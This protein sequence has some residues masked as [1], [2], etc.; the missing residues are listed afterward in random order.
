M[1]AQKHILV[2]EPRLEGHHLSWL[3]FVVEDFLS[4][5]HRL[6]LAID[7]RAH[8]MVLYREYLADLLNEVDVIS[9][10]GDDNHFKGR[11]KLAALHN[12]FRESRADHAF[13]NNLDD[14]ASRMLRR[15]AFGKF[16]PIALKGRIS[17]V[18]FRPRFLGPSSWSIN[19]MLKG[20]G[21]RRLI[22]QGWFHCICLLDEYIYR[23]NRATMPK[24]GL[25]F[26][27]DTW[28]G[29]FGMSQKMAREKL[30]I[31]Q[32]KFVFLNYGTGTR[33]KGLHLIVQALQSDDAPDHWHLLAAGQLG[34]EKKLKREVDF[35]ADQG[36]VTV[37]DRY[38]SKKEE[39]LCF[40]AVDVV[41]LPYV[42]HFGSSGVLS[43][44]TAAG[45]RVIASDDGLIGRRV[46]EH[47]LGL[48]FKSRNSNA[49]I[50]AMAESEAQAAGQVGQKPA[51]ATDYA[52]LCNRDEFRKVLHTI[53][54]D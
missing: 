34:I 47:S 9:V 22:S 1:S 6:T 53:S 40:C 32:D 38:V 4:A 52:R 31:G 41:M 17:G 21:F 45:K 42:R 11:T 46:R 39:A 26:L 27:P 3:Q 19:T 2:F 15:A 35:L 14:I 36:R 25:K 5:G 13:V 30:G 37:I 10:Y 48:V 29:E 18:Y 16:P 28:V 44:A 7:G 24:A 12:C 54:F 49:L 20:I 33:R 50:Q 8:A 51:A 43:L 23:A